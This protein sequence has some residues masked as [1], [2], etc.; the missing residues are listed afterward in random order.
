MLSISPFKTRRSRTSPATS[1]HFTMTSVCANATAKN[2]ATAVMSYMTG[3]FDM[4]F[5]TD[6]VDRTTPVA[7]TRNTKG[8]NALRMMKIVRTLFMTCTLICVIHLEGIR[9]RRLA[10]IRYIFTNLSHLIASPMHSR[11]YG[12]LRDTLDFCYFTVL[13][14]FSYI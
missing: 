2:F 9:L 8:V 3:M 10:L 6:T 5:E 7:P 13:L 14:T 4:T 12:S 11:F 1:A